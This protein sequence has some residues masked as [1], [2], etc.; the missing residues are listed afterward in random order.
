MFR[1][2]E[3]TELAR[4]VERVSAIYRDNTTHTTRFGQFLLSSYRVV[5]SCRTM[6]KARPP[7]LSISLILNLYNVYET[8]RWLESLKTHRAG[9][10]GKEKERRCGREVAG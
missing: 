6:H 4:A 8:T 5:V 10:W 3:A 9:G 2:S 1:W 7:H